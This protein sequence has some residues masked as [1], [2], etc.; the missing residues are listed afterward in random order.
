MSVLL[1]PYKS[2]FNCVSIYLVFFMPSSVNSIG[3]TFNL[4]CVINMF[5]SYYLDCFEAVLKKEVPQLSRPSCVLIHWL[6]QFLILQ[7]YLICVCEC[8]QS[9]RI[10]LHIIITLSSIVCD[11]LYSMA[12]NLL[13][14]FFS[15]GLHQCSLVTYASLLLDAYDLDH[16][17][18]TCRVYSLCESCV[19]SLARALL[20]R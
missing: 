14:A 18:W 8:L 6:I 5:A 17:F 19:P 10:V 13:F 4:R 1:R 2:L 3:F 16:L 11:I 9:D 20:A 15:H 12:L 7:L